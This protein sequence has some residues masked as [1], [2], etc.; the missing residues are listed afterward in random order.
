MYG[1]TTRYEEQNKIVEEFIQHV[2]PYEKQEPLRIDLRS[3]ARY[4][5]EN[6]IQPD[7]VT[8]E[9]CEQ[10]RLSERQSF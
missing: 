1:Q 6:N 9:M 10:F 5:Q 2:N 3:Y 8:E 7:Q 4:I